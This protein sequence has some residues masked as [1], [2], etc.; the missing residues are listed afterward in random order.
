M[1][2]ATIS[3]G[4]IL[5]EISEMLSGVQ[6]HSCAPEISGSEERVITNHGIRMLGIS[7]FVILNI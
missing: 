1:T 4:D 5:Q 3:P 7:D 6:T 2:N